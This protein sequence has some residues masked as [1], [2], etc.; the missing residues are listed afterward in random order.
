MSCAFRP[1]ARGLGRAGATRSGRLRWLRLVAAILLASSLGACAPAP[2][3]P[4][5]VLVSIDSLRPDHLGAYGYGRPTSPHLDRIA[6]QGIVFTR[7][8]STTSW[9]LPSHLSLFTGLYPAEHGVIVDG[10]RLAATIPLLP[11][12][13]A[14]GGYRSAAVV[15]GPYL[16]GGFGFAR[17]WEVYDDSLVSGDTFDPRAASAHEKITSPTVHR[18]AMELLDRLEGGRFLLF[19][20]YFDV[21]YDYLPPA[22]WDRAF[23]PDYRGAVDG[24]NVEHDA[25]VSA[26]MVPRDLDHLVA[27][28]DGEIRWVDEWIGRLDAELKRRN[29]D[30]RTLFVIT[31]DHGE[32]F[33]EHGEKSHHKNLYDTS[34]RIP[35]VIRLPDGRFAGRRVA[36]PVSLVDLLPTLMAQAGVDPPADRRGRDLLRTSSGDLASL[37]ESDLFASLHQKLDVIVRGPWK[38]LENRRG[39]RRRQTRFELYE[40]T[41]DPGERRNLA[42]AEKAIGSRLLL[43]LREA[44]VGFGALLQRNPPERFELSSALEQQL[45]S[46]GYL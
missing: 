45:R 25:R 10:Q 42:R 23:D 11:E 38:L 31:A 46:L 1:G 5:I 32:E 40:T 18:R 35:L 43:D 8:Y 17:G 7:A 15:S 14:R 26:T 20:H 36:S 2:S 28:Y 24:R 3:A 12:L 30:R 44:R 6:A 33:F 16:H 39:E 41:A 22:P 4:N 27:L 21:H 13:L 9:T 37:A 19:L 29:L 34:L